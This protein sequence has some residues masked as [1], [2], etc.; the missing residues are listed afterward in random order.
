VNEYIFGRI[1]YGTVSPLIVVRRVERGYARPDSREPSGFEDGITNP[2]NIDKKR[3]ID[4]F[5]FVHC[6]D[7]EPAWCVN[8]TVAENRRRRA[9][10][11]DE[12]PAA[13]RT[14][15]HRDA[16]RSPSHLSP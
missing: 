12:P 10:T 13:E 9:R 6:S 15:L 8:G 4:R 5:V 14:G 7:A 2:K 11:Q 16:R 3:E 1:L